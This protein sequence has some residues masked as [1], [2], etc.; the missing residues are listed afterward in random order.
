MQVCRADAF[1]LA[2]QLFLGATGSGDDA[3]GEYI[4]AILNSISLKLALQGTVRFICDLSVLSPDWESMCH[5][6]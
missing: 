6:C 4:T 2:L 5:S 1:L 3:E